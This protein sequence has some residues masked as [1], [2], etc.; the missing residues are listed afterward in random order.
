MN[1]VIESNKSLLNIKLLCYVK[2]SCLS[3][4]GATNWIVKPSS[5]PFGGQNDVDYDYYQ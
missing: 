2:V 1:F 5:W 4:P 3:T